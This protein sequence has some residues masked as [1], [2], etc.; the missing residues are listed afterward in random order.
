MPETEGGIELVPRWFFPKSWTSTSKKQGKMS[1]TSD[2]GSEHSRLLPGGATSSGSHSSNPTPADDARA[3][4]FWK[5]LRQ[6]AGFLLANLFKFAILGIVITLIVLVSIHGF[7]VFPR[8]L[9]WFKSRSGWGGW[10]AYLGIYTAIVA[11]FIPGVVFIMGA[12]FVFGFWRGLLA[13]WIGG[14]VGQALAFLLARYLLRDWVETFI[15]NKWKKWKYIDAA[16]EKDGWKLV[17]IMRMS[18]II[19]YNLLNIAMA[20]TSIHF[21]AFSVV[22]SIGIIFECCIFVYLGTIADGITS[23]VEGHAGKPKAIQWVLMGLSIFMGIVGAVFVSIMIRRA[24]SNADDMST[25]EARDGMERL[26][27]AP[28][29]GEGTVFTTVGNLSTL[30][31]ERNQSGS[32]PRWQHH[33]RNFP[34]LSDAEAGLGGYMD[35]EKSSPRPVDLAGQPDVETTPLRIRKRTDSK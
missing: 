10:G 29:G 13:V 31:P 5:D 4:R 22:S 34:E 25:L 23:I 32:G 15:N 11:L 16:L 6:V 17:L 27:D 3:R 20:T 35:N 14:S 7:S 19:P 26:S 8:I 12:G 1:T 9:E 2:S 21:L 33:I 30:T 18:P 24:I 28:E